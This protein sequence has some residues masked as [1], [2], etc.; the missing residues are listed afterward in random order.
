MSE[1]SKVKRTQGLTISSSSTKDDFLDA[2]KQQFSGRNVHPFLLGRGGVTTSYFVNPS[3]L[4][5]D[6][7]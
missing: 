4:T 6:D 7:R 1:A 3:F 2:K 5:Q